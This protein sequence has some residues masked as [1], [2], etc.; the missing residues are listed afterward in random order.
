[1]GERLFK[2]K[3]VRL[4]EEGVGD[5]P[6]DKISEFRRFHEKKKEKI[7]QQD[8]I[9]KA[10]NNTSVFVK[11][12]NSSSES[13]EVNS[14]FTEVDTVVCIDS[15]DRNIDL[16]PSQNEFETFLGKNFFNVS[17]V[18]LVSTEIPNTDQVIKQI[19]LELKNNRIAWQNEED[20]DIGIFHNVLFYREDPRYPGKILLKIIDHG[21][22]LEKK[23]EITVFN[24][25]KSDELDI[26][27][28]IDGMKEALVIDKDTF[29]FDHLDPLVIEGTTSVDTGLY[30]YTVDVKPGNYSARSLALQIQTD[31]SKVK[32]RGGKGQF[33]F[34]EVSVNLDTDIMVFDSVITTRVPSNSLATIAG[35]T[36]ITV[37]QREHGFKTGDRVKMIGVKQFAGIPS[38]EL[39]GDFIVTLIDSN[40]FSIEVLTRA[41]ES[42]DGGGNTIRTGKGA[43]F[44]LLFDTEM[45]KIQF[46][47]GFPDEDSSES[48]PGTES[49]VSV[50]ALDISNVEKIDQE[51]I[52]I[53]TTEYHGL[54][55]VKKF[56]IETIENYLTNDVLFKTSLPHKLELPI[57]I[58]IRDTNCFPEIKGSF[59]AF[60]NGIDTFYIKNSR[61]V[62]PGTVGTL[63]YN[64]DRVKIKGLDTVPSIS[65]NPIFFVE[66][67]FDNF[68][69]DIKFNL[70]SINLDSIPGSTVG[71]SRLMIKHPDHGFNELVSIDNHS[72]AGFLKVLLSNENTST[73]GRRVPGS[74]IEDGPV[75]TNSIDIFVPFHFLQTSDSITVTNSTS[76]PNINGEYKIQRITDN[77]VRINFIHENADFV[78][79]TCT[80]LIGESVVFSST[81]CFP[82]VNGNFHVDNTRIVSNI[83]EGTIVSTITTSQPHD[84]V[85][86]DEIILA[87]TNSTPVLDGAFVVFSVIDDFNFSVSGFQEEIVLGGNFG[88]LTFS[89][90]F[91]IESPGVIITN[92]GITP[93]GIIGKDNYVSLY[94]VESSIDLGSNIGDIS[95]SDINQNRRRINKIIDKNSYMIR[96]E[97]E[98]SNISDTSN[99]KKLINVS[100]VFHGFAEKLSNTIDGTPESKLF[101]SISLEGQNYIFLTLRS[102][103]IDFKTVLNTSNVPD[104]FAKIILTES[105]GLMCF[106]TFIS[107]PKKFIDPIA[108]LDTLKLK[109]VDSKGFLFDFNQINFSLTLKIT[110]LIENL[111]DT[112][113]NSRSNTDVRARK[114]PSVK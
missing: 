83:S 11:E 4:G 47:T 73:F 84:L 103:G 79:G 7:K 37:N 95:L 85:V 53:T 75:S 33:H 61:I 68:S 102:N 3:F 43:P 71:T 81:N 114:P 66:N 39:N 45:T 30:V 29:V 52:R 89:K 26:S 104:T 22:E 100:S 41:S 18:Q 92:P 48:I 57:K 25:K 44:R 55:I 91:I 15:R 59:F 60:P 10:N 13:P 110:E 80:V 54:E 1:M 101:R 5:I 105:P 65:Q 94:R 70:E 32:R 14:S 112:G 62:L 90:K 98:Y 72:R 28:I 56:E 58:F 107:E 50:S 8:I 49:G 88:M 113:L 42:T 86:G 19:P 20:M 6:V 31:M 51:T 76:F 108:R 24:S 40:S 99:T 46:N 97:E 96:V 36:I 12:N 67:I 93:A 77:V 35:T 109:V 82:R 74:V 87:M 111:N 34:F 64:G 16:Y 2:N 69:F 106:N 78:P 38:I 27:G 9:N 23:I 21:V 17:K 63:L